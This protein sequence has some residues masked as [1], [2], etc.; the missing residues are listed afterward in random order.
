MLENPAARNKY[1]FRSA[2][3]PHDL[4]AP[5]RG[6]E[7]GKLA[8][9]TAAVKDIF[10]IQGERT[11]FGSPD[12][13]EAQLPAKSNAVAV[14]RILDQGATIV[15]KTICDELCFSVTGANPFYGTPLNPRAT[16]RLPAGSSS[17]SASATAAGSCDFAL[18]GDTGGSVRIPAALCGVYGIRPTFGRVDLTGVSVMA[19]SFDCA[20]W[21][22]N[23]PGVLRVVGDVMLEGRAV[24]GELTSC[25]LVEDAFE[26]ADS[27]VSDLLQDILLKMRVDL[28]RMR[29][30]CISPSGLD[31]WRE[32]FRIVQA[33]DFWSKYGPFMSNRP[34]RMSPGVKERVEFTSTVT[35]AQASAARKTMNDAHA[36]IR[37]IVAPGTILALPTAPSIAPKLDATPSDL[38]LFRSRVMRL[39]TI[40]GLSGLP[41]IT[42]PLGSLHDA[43]VGLSFI[44]WAG[45][46]E[47]LLDLACT[48]SKYTGVELQ[49]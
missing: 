8:G 3:V 47:V 28:P 49:Y 24:A 34:V 4:L 41:Q 31:T 22:A 10:D 19:S 46:D 37:G 43:P 45:S 6:A 42:I 14:Q 11:G 33:H 7:Q 18:G 5:V 23:G 35:D 29:T 20:G 39:T 9:L 1:R 44:G 30:M 25:L 13:Y 32:V 21:F 27:E 12:W 2:F 48:L 16:D 38:D 15:G 36:H 26:S 40:S 17:G